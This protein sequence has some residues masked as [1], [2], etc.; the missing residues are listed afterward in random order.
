MSEPRR[1]HYVPEFYLRGF[2]TQ[3]SPGK[4]IVYDKEAG[5]AFGTSVKNAA[6]KRDYYRIVPPAD[7][8]VSPYIL[9]EALSESEHKASK[10]LPKLIVGESLTNDERAEWAAFMALLH[11]RG[12][13]AR[14]MAAEVMV[15]L[16]TKMMDVT[17]VKKER[18]EAVFE[19]ARAAGEEMPGGVTYDQAVEF[20]KS[21]KFEIGIVEAAS[22]MSL[23]AAPMVAEILYDMEWMIVRCPPGSLLVTS[24]NP[25]IYSSPRNTHHPLMGDGG[26]MNKSVQVRLP[27]TKRCM[28]IAGWQ[29]VP[30]LIQ[31]GASE[32]LSFNLDTI[33][34]AFR[35]AYA[36]FT[37]DALVKWAQKT[38]GHRR[39]LT[40]TDLPKVALRRNL[41]RDS[42][43]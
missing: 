3:A 14:M 40:S 13:A 22:L 17:L 16:M 25:V 1:H 34:H 24:D 35:Y 42:N 31:V 27:L 37:D 10:V 5:K 33:A 28:L 36:P 39:I 2:A 30:P 38:K 21:R 23:E 6:V 8:D 15:S 43:E 26:L 29:K 7:K 11:L 18:Y 20:W 12:P 19:R 41:N 9:E 4:V 32:I